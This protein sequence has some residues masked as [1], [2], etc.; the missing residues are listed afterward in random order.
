ME[1]ERV[2][3]GDQK[4]FSCDLCLEEFQ[5]LEELADHKQRVHNMSRYVCRVCGMHCT[6]KEHLQEHENSHF[7]RELT[8]EA[9]YPCE[10]CHRIFTRKWLLLK[11]LE[12]HKDIEEEHSRMRY[13]NTCRQNFTSIQDYENHICMSW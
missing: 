5:S 7:L 12:E 2:F 1:H 13:C 10:V 8:S 4:V 6:S 3:H 11:H 9:E